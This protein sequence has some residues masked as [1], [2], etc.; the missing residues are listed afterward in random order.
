MRLIFL[1]LISALISAMIAGCGAPRQKYSAE[2][3]MASNDKAGK[4]LNIEVEWLKK[5]KK[6]I[7]VRFRAVNK[8]DHDILLRESSF[9]LVF[10]GKEGKVFKH[11]GN[12]DLPKDTISMHVVVFSFPENKDDG[13][14][15]L[16]I[17]P[18]VFLP[19]GPNA[20][21]LAPV[22]IEL[23]VNSPI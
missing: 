9:K 15:K 8:H 7:D 11:A 1:I 10:N 12:L 21:P 17:T 13:T 18:Y 5:K 23:P 20:K 4:G 14:A 3:S 6:Y 16:T 19:P 22:N 2:L